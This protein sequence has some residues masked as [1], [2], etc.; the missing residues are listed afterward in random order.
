MLFKY[1]Y[2]IRLV[3]KNGTAIKHLYCI[4]PT[5]EHASLTGDMKT[6][7]FLTEWAEENKKEIL[8]LLGKKKGVCQ[9]LCIDNETGVA[10]AG[11]G[12]IK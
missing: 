4:P 3:N 6:N 8:R 2:E 1:I 12:Y 7:L 11:S 5:L 10:I 9:V